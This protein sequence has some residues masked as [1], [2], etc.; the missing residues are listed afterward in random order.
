MLAR[1]A[2]DNE[3]FERECTFQPLDLKRWELVSSG[4]QRYRLTFQEQDPFSLAAV[5]RSRSSSA[6]RLHNGVGRRM[7]NWPGLPDIENFVFGGEVTLDIRAL[8]FSIAAGLYGGLHLLAWEAPF[9]S[10]SE[11]WL[12]RGSGLVL[13]MSGP[14]LL[15]AFPVNLG[16]RVSGAFRFKARQASGWSYVRFTMLEFSIHGLCFP[17]GMI[18]LIMGLAYIPARI[19]LIVE[20]CLQLARLPPGAYTTPNWSKYYPHIS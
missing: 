4:W 19:F 2:D 7:E 15:C 20:S 5:H 13:M 6:A 8:T 14:V 17:F 1:Q 3:P 18:I 16:D 9:G 10:E 12:W 11:Q